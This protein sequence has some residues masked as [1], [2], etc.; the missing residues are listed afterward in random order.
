MATARYL[1]NMKGPP[2]AHIATILYGPPLP[3]VAQRSRLLSEAEQGLNDQMQR[4][5]VTRMYFD[6]MSGAMALDRGQREKGMML[7]RR[8]L[9]GFGS[10][11]P[12]SLM[13]RMSLAHALQDEGRLG[14]A[15]EIL[16]RNTGS[17]AHEVLHPRAGGPFPAAL[18]MRTQIELMRIYR[19]TGRDEAARAIESEL[20]KLL[21]YADPDFVP[22]RELNRSEELAAPSLS[23]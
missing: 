14:E 1:L 6:V 4:R 8:G 21:A 19:R 22:L 18:W 12:A 9:K 11:S 2:S 5:L 16:E 7:V 13:G 15:A 17:I 3:D 23:R 20:R 10:A